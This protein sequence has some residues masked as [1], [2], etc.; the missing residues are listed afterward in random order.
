MK[1][2]TVV[3]I[4]SAVVGTPLIAGITWLC[5]KK[6]KNQ[7]CELNS[8]CCKFKSSEQM[9]STIREEVRVVIA[10]LTQPGVETAVIES[11][12]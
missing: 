5:T 11:P 7:S 4:L 8:G 12:V 9:R 6:C 10:E 3:Y 1:D 2:E